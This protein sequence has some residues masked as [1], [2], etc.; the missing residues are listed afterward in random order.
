MG[1]KKKDYTGA[2]EVDRKQHEKPLTKPHSSQPQR[3]NTPTTPPPGLTSLV[4]KTAKI[5]QENLSQQQEEGTVIWKGGNYRGIK[6][7]CARG[8]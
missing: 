5:V 8:R 2:K 3:Q 6:N 7:R 4:P 1:K